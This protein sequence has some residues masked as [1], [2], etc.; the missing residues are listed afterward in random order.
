MSEMAA[1][2]AFG[3]AEIVVVTRIRAISRILASHG[4]EY[5]PTGRQNAA[6]LS[7]PLGSIW[8]MRDTDDIYECQ[9]VSIEHADGSTEC[10]DHTCDLQHELHSFHVACTELYP[11]CPCIPEEH[12]LPELLVAA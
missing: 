1:H 11:P 4:P 5:R 8:S 6:S 9:G 10:M 12:E 7:H 3:D 2:T